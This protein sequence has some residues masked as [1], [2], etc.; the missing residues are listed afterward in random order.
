MKQ[1]LQTLLFVFSI[2]SLLC[3]C[4]AN[5]SNKLSVQ[6]IVIEATQVKS[7]NISH[8]E[9]PD[10]IKAPTELS[11]F[12]NIYPSTF[13]GM[14]PHSKYDQVNYLADNEKAFKSYTVVSRGKND[15][16][17]TLGY[18]YRDFMVKPDIESIKLSNMPSVTWLGHGA[19]LMKLS[20]GTSLLT[21]P[22]FGDFDGIIGSLSHFMFDE[23]ERIAPSVV[24]TSELDFVDGVLIS[25]NHYDHFSMEAI[26]QL[27][28]NINYYVPLNFE[29]Y[30]ADDF[31]KVYEMD[32]YTSRQFNL[33]KVH[34]VPA[35]HYSGRGY[36]D[37]NETLWGGWVVESNDLKIYFSGDT[38]YTDIFKDIVAE[39]GKMDVCLMATVA[40][41]FDGRDIHM[42]P[43]DAL[44][45]ADELGCSIFIPWGYGTWATGYEHVLEP[46]RRLRH[47]MK[48]KQYQFK[49]V[50]LKMGETLT[51][52]N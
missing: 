52:E 35:H 39:Y 4:V 24:T 30:F 37:K 17:R 44:K 50:E 7:T 12:N 2:S 18:D 31:N 23:F 29:S 26:E 14:G 22:V 40:Y 20:D 6:P 36:F 49:I 15:L 32:W 42:A 28:A 9:L 43:E 1:Q 21:D 25:H 46:L 11:E 10:T 45:A 34:F 8:P 16:D 41:A 48:D 13:L 27:G 5:G 33:S 51:L 3:A 47:A 38:G 19:F